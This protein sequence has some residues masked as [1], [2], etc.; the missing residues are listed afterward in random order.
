MSEANSSATPRQGGNIHA[1]EAS[2]GS[3]GKGKATEPTQDVSMGEAEDD[4]DED[5]SGDEVDEVTF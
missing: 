4:D 3:K 2:S 1:T 5:T